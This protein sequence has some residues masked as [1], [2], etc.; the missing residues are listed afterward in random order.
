VTAE[1]RLDEDAWAPMLRVEYHRSLGEYWR[2]GGQIS[3]VKKS[4]DD[5]SGGA[6]DTNVHLESFPWEN[7]GF[8]L[9]YNYDDVDL[10][11]D[12][13]GFAGELNFKNRGPQIVATVRF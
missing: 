12:R 11:F 3:C 2:M 7:F 8:G 9:R 1:E 10:D 6:V 5:T 13:S 4:G